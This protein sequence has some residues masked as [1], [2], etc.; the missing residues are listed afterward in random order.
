M[1]RFAVLFVLTA[2]I[3]LAGAGVAAASTTYPPPPPTTVPPPPTSPPT[4][5]TGSND[6]EGAVGLGAVL[7]VVGLGVLFVAKK[8]AERLTK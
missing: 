2:T 4:A 1:K 5:L 3:V 7:L 6:I 8:R